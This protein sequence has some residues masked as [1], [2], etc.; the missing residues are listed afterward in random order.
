MAV[1]GL[2]DVIYHNLQLFSSAN[3]MW[4]FCITPLPVFL[5]NPFIFCVYMPCSLYRCVLA[6]GNVLFSTELKVLVN[7]SVYETSGP[8]GDDYGAVFRGLTPCIMA[9]VDRGYGGTS[10]LHL[11]SKGVTTRSQSSHG[12]YIN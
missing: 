7:M 11:Q 12:V 3:R 5:N 9:Q 2:Y 8:H 4:T 6:A 10:C 1:T